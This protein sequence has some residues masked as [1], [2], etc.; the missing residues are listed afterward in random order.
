MPKALRRPSGETPSP[1]PPRSLSPPSRSF[2]RA[3]V[4]AQLFAAR[5]PASSRPVRLYGLEAASG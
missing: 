5:P 3:E 2:K 1:H 4:G